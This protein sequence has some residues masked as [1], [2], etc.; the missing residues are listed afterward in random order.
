LLVACGGEHGMLSQANTERFVISGDYQK[1]ADCAFGAIRKIEY[2]AVQRTE[3]PTQRKILVALDTGQVRYWELAFS[4]APDN[5]RATLV[6]V[7]SARTM[8]GPY[9]SQK[10]VDAARG[11]QS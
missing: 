5:A 9:P 6:E 1:V 3:V 2:A 8:W 7:S 10:A 11:C 4:P